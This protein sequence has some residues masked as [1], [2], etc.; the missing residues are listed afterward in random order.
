MEIVQL[1]YL[2]FIVVLVVSV[3]LDL[4]VFGKKG[5]ALD[6]KATLKSSIIQY[7]VWFVIAIGY[8]LFLYTQYDQDASLNYLI[9]YFTEMSLSI[10]NLFVFIL[11]FS[12]LKIKK[13]NIG[14]ALTIGILL[15][16]VFRIVFIFIGIGIVNRFEWVLAIFGIFLLYTGVKIFFIKDD[17]DETERLGKIENFLSNKMRFTNE[18]SQGQ[19]SLMLNGK[20]YFTKLSLAVILI[21][22]SDIMFAI[23][24]IPAVLAITTDKLIVYSSN[25][26]AI[27][28]LRPLYII[29]QKAKDK[30]DYV[31]EGVSIVLIFIG[32]K[33]LL[34]FVW[35]IEIPTWL[36]FVL[37]IGILGGSVVY[38]FFNSKGNKK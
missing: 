36:S 37:I 12:T 27:L 34:H 28:G 16:I 25:I 20:R 2:I 30:F 26:F 38:S 35:H 5:A 18:D 15:A 4:G 29:L 31:Q 24:S 6:E 7:A 14:K 21:G 1:S 3:I 23:D 32:V 22:V 9:A 33:I 13:E 19:Y 11:V 8:F 17:G 10:D